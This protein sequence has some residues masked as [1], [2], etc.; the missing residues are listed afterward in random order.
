MS[1]TMSPSRHDTYVERRR[2]EK[3]SKTE[4]KNARRSK[5]RE[6]SAFSH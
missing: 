4:R 6:R 2:A 3:L 1:H 5:Q